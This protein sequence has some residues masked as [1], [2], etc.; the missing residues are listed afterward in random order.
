M[1]CPCCE[2]D[3]F[4]GIPREIVICWGCYARMRQVNDTILMIECSC[5]KH[6]D[7]KMIKTLML[8]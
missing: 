3:Y 7:G 4:G 1:N 5:G 8:F 6:D 2:S